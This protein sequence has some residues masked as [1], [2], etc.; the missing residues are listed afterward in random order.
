MKIFKILSA[1]ALIAIIPFVAN[2]GLGGGSMGGLKGSTSGT[3]SGGSIRT[4]ATP[5]SVK[6]NGLPTAKTKSKSTTDNDDP[7]TSAR[8]FT[9]C[10]TEYK[11]TMDGDCE[12]TAEPH[13]TCSCSSGIKSIESDY[14]LDLAELASDLNK[15]AD[16]LG[17]RGSMRSTNETEDFIVIQQLISELESLYWNNKL[18]NEIDSDFIRNHNSIMSGLEN[19]ENYDQQL[20][21]KYM[22]QITVDCSDYRSFLKIYKTNAEKYK[23]KY[24]TLLVDNEEEE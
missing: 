21:S 23:N 10:W 7:T 19:C 22:D 4:S 17:Q 15:I 11:S 8:T 12:P 2:A 18:A 9:S 3:S 6:A 24:E 5:K 16:K 14:Q 1:I 13:K 20:K